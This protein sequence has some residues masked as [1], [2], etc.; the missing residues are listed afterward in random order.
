M[1]T[2]KLTLMFLA[3]AAASPAFAQSPLPQC[4]SA[5]FDQ[6]QNVFTIANPAA[7]AV[8]QQCLIT[9]LP[10]GASPDRQYPGP[11]FVEGPYTIEMSG[12]GGGGSGGASSNMGGGGGGAG[13]A[14]LRA[15]KYLAPGVYKLT[16]GTGGYGGSADGG[17][18]GHGN[19][20]SLTD[21]NTGQVI[22]GFPGADAWT[23]SSQVAGDGRGG[24]A[25]AGGSTGGNG[26]DS[27]P[28][29][30]EAA[31]PGGMLQVGGY[32][33]RPGQ[34]GSDAGRSSQAN[35]GG[36]GG[37]GVGDGGNGQSETSNM[38][39]GTGVL[40]GGGGGGRGGRNT[41]TAGSQ[42]GHGFIR[43]AQSGPAPQA[44]APEPTRAVGQAPVMA[45]ATE[46]VA[47]PPPAEMRPARIDRN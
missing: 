29:K 2:A 33:G 24:R 15:E 17:P 31:Q 43:L 22:L 40:G 3:C 20:T 12:G 7:G 30:E 27:G 39:A 36:G 28:N 10:S 42:G 14:P 26:G 1:K 9:V 34:A 23:P 25:R 32:S 35:A 19:P 44:I 41:A 16:I 45:P 18:T 13:A 8:N 37:A 11:Y 38:A 6:T 4:G 21:F 47:P 5:N 46:S